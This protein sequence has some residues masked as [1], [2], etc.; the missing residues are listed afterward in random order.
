LPGVD[1]L[2]SEEGIK[3]LAEKYPHELL[4]SVV[5]QQLETERLAITAGNKC[6]SIDEMVKA[7]SAQLN[8]LESPSLRP[9]INAT[10]VVLH[11]N[12]GRA[13][14]SPEAIAAMGTIAGRFSTLEFDI[15]TGRR[16]SR[17]VHIEQALCRLSGAEAALVVNNNASAVMLA[18]TALARRKE[19]IVSRG[20][21]VEIGGSFRIPD[22]MRQSG[23]KLVEVGTTNCTYITDYEE[24][25]T[26][27]T[28]ALMR[29]HSSNFQ[30]VGF[31]HF[32]TFEELTALGNKYELPVLDD[33][34][35]GCFLETEQFGLAHEPMVQQSISAGAG[36]ACFSGDKLVGGPQAGII[37]GKK[38]LVDKLR[39]HPLAR[40]VRIDKIRLAGLA[41]TLLHYLKGE[42]AEKIPVWQMISAPLE[43]M[44]RRAG[45][46][47]KAL[48]GAARVIDGESMVGGG[49][50]PGSALPTK[51]V[52]IGGGG[53]GR[54]RISAQKLAVKLRKSEKCPV[55][56]RISEGVLLLDP[57]SVLP[58]EDE[59]ILGAL[60]DIAADLKS[61]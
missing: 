37:V 22:V 32:I 25:I 44:E 48:G 52:A 49:S 53:G 58:G 34:G 10:G 13:S 35:S 50:L 17:N 38:Q 27:R 47:A 14:L 18:L 2:L 61:T 4:V 24:A 23:A 42:A 12:I 5:R 1:R 45:T 19:V 8:S 31:T 20:E 54:K 11:T 26:P 15:E 33:L 55:I 9:V 30:V 21:A 41:A 40:A 29:V 7:I 43:E 60:G 57:R 16:G 56:G 46:W 28:A 3:Q 39:R 59:I 36:L 6:S 51:L